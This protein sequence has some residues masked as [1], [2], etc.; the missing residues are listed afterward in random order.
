MGYSSICNILAISFIL[1]AVY[2][3]KVVISV[4]MDSSNIHVLVVLGKHKT[5]PG[6]T[7]DFH[8]V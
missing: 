8:Q 6:I 3:F 4:V 7:A 1:C 2:R 5:R